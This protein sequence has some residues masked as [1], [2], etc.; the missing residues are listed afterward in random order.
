MG[1]SHRFVV[2]KTL[3]PENF[4]KLVQDFRK[5]VKPLEHLGVK[6]AG[7]LGEGDPSLDDDYIGFNG[8]KNCGHQKRNMGLMSPAPGSKGIA[9]PRQAD[10]EVIETMGYNGSKTN[11]RV[12]DGECSYESF[13]LEQEKRLG[14]QSPESRAKSRIFDSTKTNYKPYDLAVTACLI[15]AK[16]H[17]RDQIDITTDGKQENWDDARMVCQHFL[18]YGQDIGLNQKRYLIEGTGKFT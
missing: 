14:Y 5:I 17:L 11:T 2:D 3:D 6:L 15:I 4:L 10:Q 9:N 7:P 16:H 8:V 1:Y 13:T 18:G 12:C